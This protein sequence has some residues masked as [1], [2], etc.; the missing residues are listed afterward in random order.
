MSNRSVQ[1]SLFL[2]LVALCLPFSAFAV[3]VKP[4][5][6]PSAR[7]SGLGGTHAALSDDFNTLF[8]NPAG[9]ATVKDELSVTELSISLYGPIFEIIDTIRSFSNDEGSLDISGLVG[10]SGLF[11]GMDFG[12]PIS[13]GWVGKGLGFGLFNHTSLDAEASGVNI[14][15][16]AA[17]EFLVLGGYAFRVLTRGSSYLDFGFLGKGFLRGSVEMNASIFSVTDLLDGNPLDTQPMTSVA[18]VG[19]DLGLR[20]AFANSLTLGLVCHDIF[21]PA[22]VSVYPS[23][24]AFLSGGSSNLESSY[25]KIQPKLNIGFSYTPHFTL[26]D[27]FVNRAQ[28]FLD[29]RDFLDLFALIPRNPILNVSLGTELVVLNVLSLRAAIADALPQFGFGLDLRFMQLDFAMRGIE[30]GLDPGI[31]PVFAMDCGLLFRY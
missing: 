28:I 29:Y 8:T 17:E 4:F 9:F 20:Y 13:L 23:T 31:N 5:T 14:G 21:S 7:L 22:L 10:P 1:F 2:G 27:R 24:N 15:A 6:M 12:G 18:G 26:L 25:E 11:T 19:L 3:D 30:L 16:Q